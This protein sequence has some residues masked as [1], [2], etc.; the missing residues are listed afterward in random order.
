[1]ATIETARLLLRG[2]RGDD[3]EPWIAMNADPRVSEFLGRPHGRELDVSLAESMRDRLAA[4]GYGWWVV[5]VRGGPSFAGVVAL[6]EVPFEAPFTPAI[7]IGWRLAP[8]YW[9]CG[10]ATEAARGVIRFA[11]ESLGVDQ[12]VAFTAACNL[13]SARVMQRLG[14]T[15]DPRDDF[16][17]PRVEAGSRLHRHVLYRLHTARKVLE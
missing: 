11:F 15:N 1:V 14:M 9:G 12:V 4:H 16:D 2:W 6:Q 8:E 17:H 7:E 10:Y 5:E 3:V 13:R